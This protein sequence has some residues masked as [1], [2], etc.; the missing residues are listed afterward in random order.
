[1]SCAGIVA[2]GLFRYLRRKNERSIGQRSFHPVP[3]A[4]RPSAEPP[5]SPCKRLA[6]STPKP[7]QRSGFGGSKM[8]ATKP[9]PLTDAKIVGPARIK[10]LRVENFRALRTIELKEITPLTVLLGP[11]GRGAPRV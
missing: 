6:G 5:T 9:T 2:S 4:E 10:Y 8:M 11:N 1:M 7:H 3:N